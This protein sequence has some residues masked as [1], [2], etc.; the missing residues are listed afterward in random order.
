VVKTLRRAAERAMGDGAP[1]SAARY[2]ERALVEPPPD[3]ATHQELR[4]E[5]ARAEAA[6]GSPTAPA[7]IRDALERVDDA[8]ARTRALA[9]LVQGP[10]A[11]GDRSSIVVGAF[12][13]GLRHAHD[14]G[15]D[16]EATRWLEATLL[17]EARDDPA[18]RARARDVLGLAGDAGGAQ[19]PGARALLAQRSLESA[20]AGLPAA[21]V[22][23]QAGAAL[24][25]GVLIS[26]DRPGG[27]HVAAV[28]R[29]LA[30][31]DDLQSAELVAAV[32]VERARHSGSPDAYARVCALRADVSVRRGSLAD[33]V[34]DARA[35][36]ESPA[37]TP[38]HTATAAYAM[39]LAEH[40][41]LD[42]A[43][44]VLAAWAL[45]CAPAA[46]TAAVLCVRAHLHLLRG[47]HEDAYAAAIEAGACA[48]ELLAD[49]PAW[50]P[51]RTSAALA[52]LGAD[53][54]EARR[55]A[56][57]QLAMARRTGARRTI[58]LALRTAGVAEGGER[59]L[60]LLREAV[61]VL[62]RSH[63]TL[64]RAH[65]QAALGAA[66]RRAHDPT[67]AR[68]PLRAALSAARRCGA[69][70]LEH[71]VDGELAAA[72]DRVVRPEPIEASTLTPVERR[73]VDLAT[74]GLDAEE[75]ADAL[76][77]TVKGVE[78]HL[79]S[80]S[81][82]LGAPSSEQ[83]LASLKGADPAP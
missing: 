38:Q 43:D 40:G 72:G 27:P 44:E 34:A 36:L 61:A 47:E 14:Q 82:K 23:R 39:A 15:A 67:A 75:I 80:A 11:P 77:L 37:A 76:F 30:L 8:G 4:L 25:R 57:E 18:L 83:L 13:E 64:E 21:E 65:A 35:A 54:D 16:P 45:D 10:A 9:D 68:E 22:G 48:A 51:W 53:H 74:D 19:T 70:I 12:E 60:A 46:A 73:I 81:R 7:R 31:A 66:L 5:L 79:R 78:W 71:L 50:L 28:I 3:G 58:G 1:A 24:G 55:L 29:A 59:G 42:A 2:L 20:L 33:A 17:S 26:E 41:D 52:V 56:A 63:A 6:A 49:T 32:A 69:G 62:E